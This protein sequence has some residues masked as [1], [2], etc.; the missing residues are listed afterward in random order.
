[1]FLS[2]ASQCRPKSA[3][4]L[5]A[6]L[7]VSWLFP[8]NRLRACQSPVVTEGAAVVEGK[9][10][11][12]SG[13]PVA[14][15]V[16]RLE[17]QDS[18]SAADLPK[19]V[20]ATTDEEGRY[21]LVAPRLG[22]YLLCARA[23]AFSPLVVKNLDL[24]R[25]ERRRL[26][27]VLHVATHSGPAIE[28]NPTNQSTPDVQ[29]SDE[30]NFTVAGI[31][32]RSNMGLHG[33][34]ANVRASDVLAKEAASLKSSSTEKA[35]DATRAGDAH[36]VLG[37]SK[38]SSGDP[39]GAVR[40][41]EAA[42]KADPSEQN[43]FAWGAELLLHRAG[44][45]SVQVFLN[46]ARAHPKSS[47]MLAGLGAAY[48]SNGQY[49]EAA[50]QTCRASEL[51]PAAAAP[52]LLLGQMEKAA[53]DPLP[54]SETALARF[55]AKQPANPQASFYYG[56]VL[57]K[58]AR[59]TQDAANCA[60]AEQLFRKAL[61]ND[62]HYAEVYLQLGMLYNAR[63][64]KGSALAAFQNAAAADP[65]FSAVRYQLSLAYRRSG[66][67]AKADQEMKTYDELRRSEDAALEKERRRLRQFVTILKK[68]PSSTR[69]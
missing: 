4:L 32:D 14:G 43:Y 18:S 62:P 42:V 7:A 24:D 35:T 48:Y 44:Q 46:G 36:R 55:A 68:D 41:Y 10:I 30:T 5:C 15:A 60:R 59:K 53:A 9:V 38:E 47:R 27:P 13:A 23:E 31:T 29:F 63:G 39:V 3:V 26:D 25:P 19:T 12:E 8:P 1:M 17:P 2:L 34:D 64:E 37:D 58:R 69:E 54:C 51:D 45:P 20:T 56:L 65:K 21:V 66:D 57:W 6:C 67:V 61:E 40:E 52:Y 33:S 28:P 50:A 11:D 16:L 22:R 49:N